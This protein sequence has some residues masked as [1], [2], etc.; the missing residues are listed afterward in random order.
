M[1]NRS[2]DCGRVAGSNG[3]EPPESSAWPGA[4]GRQVGAAHTLHDGSQL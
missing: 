2:I 1:T 4:D 3:S